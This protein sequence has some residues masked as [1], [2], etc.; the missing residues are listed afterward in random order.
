MSFIPNEKVQQALQMDLLTYLRIYEPHELVHFSSNTYC[1]RTHD[2]LKISK[3]SG[4]GG[5]EVSVGAMP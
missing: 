4:C 2:S 1:T 3:E 5:P